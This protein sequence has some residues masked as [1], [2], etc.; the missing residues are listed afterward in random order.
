MI[1][2]TNVFS[3]PVS[4]YRQ[5]SLLEKVNICILHTACL[6]LILNFL[7]LLFSLSEFELIT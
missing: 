2:D 7:I 4:N 3:K 6:D 5:L 1:D